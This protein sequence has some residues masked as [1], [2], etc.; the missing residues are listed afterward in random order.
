MATKV[1]ALGQEI[2][3][4]PTPDYHLT[5]HGRGSERASKV[6]MG[7]DKSYQ[8]HL[9]EGDDIKKRFEGEVI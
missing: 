7:N 5:C 8:Q 6:G 2:F 9:G 3:L 4:C 1:D